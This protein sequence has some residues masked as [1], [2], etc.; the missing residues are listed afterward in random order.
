MVEGFDYEN[1]IKIWFLN[2]KV[3]ELLEEY[4]KRY[5][6]IVTKDGSFDVVNGMMNEI[7]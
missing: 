1:L 4:K 5:D 2:E 7:K 6:V 3:E